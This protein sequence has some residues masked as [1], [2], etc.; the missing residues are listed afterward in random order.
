MP[1]IIAAIRKVG[2]SI[3][4]IT[5]GDVAG[6]IFTTNPLETGIDIYLGTGGAPGGRAGGGGAALRRRPDAGPADPRHAR[7]R[8]E[9]ARKMGVTDPNKKYRME[10]LASGDVI[11]AATGVTDGCPAG[12]RQVSR[13]R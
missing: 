5:D 4:L 9:R 8:R 1:P 3:R 10:E 6:V 12:G 2:A 11:V 13:A 7:P